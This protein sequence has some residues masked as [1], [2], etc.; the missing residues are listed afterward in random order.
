MQFLKSTVATASVLA[1]LPVYAQSSVTL[2]GVVDTGIVYQNNQSSLGAT[3]GGHSAVKFASG[4]WNGNRFGLLGSEDLG[5]GT[6]V[7]FKL[8]SGFNLN[9]G[10]QQYANALFGRQSYVG[11]ANTSFGTLTAGRQYTSYYTMLSPYSPTTWLTGYFGAHPGDLDSLDT[12][13]R[14]NNSLVYTSPKLHGFTFSGSYSIGGVPGS[15]N[16]GSTWSVGAQYQ[17]GP[18]GIA[19]AVQRVNNS[20]PGGGVWGADSTTTSGGQVGVSSVTNGY[21]TAAAQQRIA[22]TAGYAFSPRWD[23]SA[24]YS[25]VQYIPGVHSSFANTATFNTAGAV[26]HFKPVLQWDLAAGYSFTRATKANGMTHAAQYQQFSLGEYY[27]LSKR[28]AIYALQ[29]FQT[30]SGQTLGTAGAGHVI[31]ATATVGDGTQSTPSSGRRVF[32][33]GVGIVHRF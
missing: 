21:Q 16:S 26:L 30:A 31:D 33:A 32:A 11:V 22:V 28:T 17:A 20:T 5:G 27:S 25:N 7:I 13:Y 24:S 8:E 3:S 9:T 2:Y 10:G 4:I 12:N 15:L 23:V 18:M 14:A 6:K 1:A 29:A 19:A